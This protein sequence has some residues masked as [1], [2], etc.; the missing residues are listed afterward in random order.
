MADNPRIEELR[1]RVQ[2][3]PA[4]IAF[5]ALA[6]EYRRVGRNED[7][8]TTCRTGLVRHPAYLSA[9]VTLGRAL[10]ETGEFDAARKELETVL[11][12]APEN[13]AATRGLAL[14]TER[15]GQSAA[16]DP[17]LAAIAEASIPAAP[18]EAPPVPEAKP[19]ARTVAP[20]LSPLQS[21]PSIRLDALDLDL[22][23]P[24]PPAQG[25]DAFDLF[26]AALERSA[27]P[28][29]PVPA[30]VP[31]TPPMAFDP[32]TVVVEAPVVVDA[33]AAGEPSPVEDVTAVA[34]AEADEAIAAEATDDAIVIDDATVMEA[35]GASESVAIDDA[36]AVDAPAVDP[37]AV[38]TLARL[39]RMLGAIRTARHA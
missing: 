11:R 32:A 10:I 19:A 16:M 9:R 2:A 24:A 29:A 38:A 6:E 20:E 33:G 12:S 1:R 35:A 34:E 36:F 39:E 3:D 5:A 21:S 7:A 27:G 13:I 28:A 25:G 18:P 31:E 8:I 23:A 15:M 37:A 17:G 14:I 4:S 22:R 30:A 26:A